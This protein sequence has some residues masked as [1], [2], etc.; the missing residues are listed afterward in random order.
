M[1]TLQVNLKSSRL[2]KMAAHQFTIG[3]IAQRSGVATSA[4]RFYEDRG[5]IAAARTEQGQRR[6]APDVLRRIAFI[7]TAQ[8]VGLTLDEITEA[9]GSLP[10]GRAPTKRDWERLSRR[11]RPRLDAQIAL[12]TALRDQLDS[13]IGCGCLSLRKCALRNPDDTAAT[14]GPGP[15]YLLG[16]QP[17]DTRR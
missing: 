15:R 1:I 16:D 13:C 11:W 14:L 9:L 4:L 8:R 17:A 10:D 12:L 5:L 3:E 2:K 7:R 6:Y